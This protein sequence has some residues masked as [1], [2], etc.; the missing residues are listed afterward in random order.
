MYSPR[1]FLVAASLVAFLLVAMLPKSDAAARANAPLTPNLTLAS[2]SVARHLDTARLRKQLE[3]TTRR[4]IDRL[5]VRPRQ[6]F[7]LAVALV[8]LKARQREQQV[9]TACVV[10][11]TV[12]RAAGGDLHAVLRGSARVRSEDSDSASR[13]L[14]LEVAVSGALRRV[15]E[16]VAL[17]HS[18]TRSFTATKVA[19]REGAPGFARP[20]TAGLALRQ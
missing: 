10:S 4:E 16:A 19:V 11:V 5:D 13:G 12:N 18:A 17:S 1:P 15:A 7:T 6:A 8:D 14:A 9:E 3:Q 20:E 2:V